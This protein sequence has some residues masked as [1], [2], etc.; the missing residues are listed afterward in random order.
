M[1]HIESLLWSQ[2]LDLAEHFRTNWNLVETV[3]DKSHLFF[4][5]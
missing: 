2:L 3:K 4:W 5:L 1:H